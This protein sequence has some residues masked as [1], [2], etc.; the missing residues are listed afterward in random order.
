VIAGEFSTRA[1]ILTSVGVA[2]L[3]FV[4]GLLASAFRPLRRQV[5]DARS[6]WER[7]TDY[8]LAALLMGWA[9]QK[10]V[11]AL[12]GL[13]GYRLG[14][15]DYAN[16]I[17]LSAVGVLVLRMIAEDVVTYSYPI[18]LT[19]QEAEAKGLW[20]G[21]RTVVVLF[22]ALVFNRTAEMFIGNSLELW[23]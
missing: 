1:E 21:Q 14:I 2:M 19:R 11:L 22:K 7:G 16:Q 6:L 13:S 3:W 23:I 10:M 17:A 20:T 5:D 8:A 9:V 4:P 18:S 12:P 15:A